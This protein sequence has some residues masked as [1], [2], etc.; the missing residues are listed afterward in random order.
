MRLRLAV[1]LMLLCSAGGAALS[2][3]FHGQRRI[4][5]VE[6]FNAAFI[7]RQNEKIATMEKELAHLQDNTGKLLVIAGDSQAR[8]AAAELEA[9]KARRD[10]AEMLVTLTEI[11][12]ELEKERARGEAERRRRSKADQEQELPGEVTENNNLVLFL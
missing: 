7:Q 1:T 3:K 10:K 6:Q 8:Q 9:E 11:A 5:E 4:F 12:R 2:W